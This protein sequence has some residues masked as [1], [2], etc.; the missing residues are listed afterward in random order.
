MK[1]GKKGQSMNTPKEEGVVAIGALARVDAA[2]DAE[3]RRARNSEPGTTSLSFDLASGR[4]I[5]FSDLHRGARNHADDF[6]RT[7]RAYNA[8]LAYYYRMGYTLVVLGDVED[9]WEERPAP[10]LKAYEHTFKLEAQFHQAGRYLRVR[11]NHDDEWQ[12]EARVKNLLAPLYGGETLKVYDSL[13]IKVMDGARELGMLF[14]VHGYQGSATSDLWPEFSRLIVRYIWR[15]IQRLTHLS[16]NTP[17]RSWSLRQSHNRALCA[18]AEQQEKL[19]L[20]A[21]HTHRPVF[22]SESHE[23]QIRKQLAELEEGLE[24][25]ASQEQ[26]ERQAEL[27][28]E[29]EWVRAQ[30]KQNPR[31]EP[32]ASS[33]KPCYFNTGCC[34]FLDGDITGLELAQGQIRLVRWPDDD[35]EP[36]RR[37]L[38]EGSLQKVLAAC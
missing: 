7:E 30:E 27:L 37:K 10:V 21:G 34:C 8:A 35:G 11:G 31:E 5:I 24:G 18:W 33:T 29:L 16:F 38:V 1:R 28:A 26:L 4:C 25:E 17:A 14:L 19:V 36:K 12:Y 22:Q 20:I 23:I 15:P 13:L 2:L 9:L 32:R 6:W 3:F